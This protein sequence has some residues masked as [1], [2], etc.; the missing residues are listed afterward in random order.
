MQSSYPDC[1]SGESRPSTQPA[2]RVAGPVETRNPWI[3]Q[4]TGGRLLCGVPRLLLRGM[5][6]AFIIASQFVWSDESPQALLSAT[7]SQADLTLVDP[8]L[9]N[10]PLPKLVLPPEPPEGLR[11][12]ALIVKAGEWRGVQCA[13]Q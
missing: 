10:T 1:H 8:E 3:R 2:G 7:T 5:T 9:S 12:P 6:I 13:V 11:L 4:T